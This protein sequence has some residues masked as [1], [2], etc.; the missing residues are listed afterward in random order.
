MS[1]KPPPP[2]PIIPNPP[3][4][5]CIVFFFKKKM[6]KKM[7]KKT[8]L[9]KTFSHKNQESEMCMW[10]GIERS[11]EEKGLLNKRWG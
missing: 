4:G 9:S 10:D 8:S 5:S 3:C 7:I 6:K 1:P 2:P 11:C